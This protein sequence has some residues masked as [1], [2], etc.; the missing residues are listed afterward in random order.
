MSDFHVEDPDMPPER[1]EAIIARA[2]ALHPDLV[3]AAGDFTS[4]KWIGTHSYSA[5]EAV[6]PLARLTAPLGVFAVLGNHDLIRDADAA[7][8]AL[9]AAGVHV[10]DY[11]AVEAGPIA[12]GGLNDRHDKSFD[13]VVRGEQ[14]TFLKMRSLPGARVLVAHG[15]DEFPV[16]PGDITLMLAG[17]THCGQIVLPLLGPLFTGSD[18]GRKYVC[19]IV[20]ENGR[21][22]LVNAGLGTSHIPVRLGAP[23]EMWLVTLA[24]PRTRGGRVP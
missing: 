4:D 6:S 11:D 3:V 20:R 2:N 18:Y 24:G 8:S 7:R 1:V 17:H 16:V 23:P 22:L 21:I 5:R 12:L 14:R 19:G 9:R 13:E 15:P 10:L